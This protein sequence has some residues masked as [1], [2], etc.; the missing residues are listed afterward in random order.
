[1]KKTLS[2]G[3]GLGLFYFILNSPPLSRD[4]T[5]SRLYLDGKK[6][7][8]EMSDEQPLNTEIYILT[9]EFFVDKLSFS[10]VS[11]IDV[12]KSLY[13][14]DVDVDSEDLRHKGVQSTSNEIFFAGRNFRKILSFSEFTLQTLYSRLA[15]AAMK[16]T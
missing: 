12:Y 10:I 3:L 11:K 16:I 8:E 1:M 9:V 7:E 6:Y 5:C 2:L 15:I 4:V 14:V 13:T